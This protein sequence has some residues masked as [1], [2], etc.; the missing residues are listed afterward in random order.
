MCAEQTEGF[1]MDATKEDVSLS[2]SLGRHSPSNNNEKPNDQTPALQK[3]GFLNN[4]CFHGIKC[5]YPLNLISKRIDIACKSGIIKGITAAET[6]F[7]HFG[8]IFYGFPSLKAGWNAPCSICVQNCWICE[9]FRAF[10]WI[11]SRLCT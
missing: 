3:H 2:C 8:E 6:F 10:L 7:Y 9:P 4:G 11:L 1:L 5:L